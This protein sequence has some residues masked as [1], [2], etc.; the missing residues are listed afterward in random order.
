MENFVCKGFN[1]AKD[2]LYKK[3]HDGGLGMLKLD[4]F[5][6]SLQCTWVKRVFN[7]CND[8]W[9]YDLMTVAEGNLEYLYRT[10]EHGEIGNTLASILKSFC[11]FYESFVRTDQNFR[12][13]CIFENRVFGFG[14]KLEHKFSTE[15]FGATLM[16]E[17]GE[18]IKAVKWEI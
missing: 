3:P 17:C 12:K 16:S 14:R 6:T 15:F 13:S 11:D 10:S 7:C 5:I 1:I 8:N 4:I 18:K 9:K 2:R